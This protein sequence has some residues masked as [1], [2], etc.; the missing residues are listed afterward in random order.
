MPQ[1]LL[2]EGPDLEAL[3][4]QVRA[5]HGA[6][7]RIVKA[8]RVRTGGVAGFFA[9]QTYE[10]TVSVARASDPERDQVP[11]RDPASVRDQVPVRPGPARAGGS[12]QAARAGWRPAARSAPVPPPRPAADGSLDGSLDGSDDPF[13]V[14]LARVEAREQGTPAVAPRTAV[15]A[16]D[17]PAPRPPGRVVA[18]PAESVPEPVTDPGGDAPP[19]PGEATFDDVLASV[20][21]QLGMTEQPVRAGELPQPRIVPASDVARD[22]RPARLVTSPPESDDRP[23]SEIVSEI[24]ARVESSTGLRGPS[25]DPTVAP[26]AIAPDVPGAGPEPDPEGLLGDESGALL[27]HLPSRFP[28]GDGAEDLAGPTVLDLRGLESTDLVADPE[29]HRPDPDP[30]P[31]PAAPPA[32]PAAPAEPGAPGGRGAAGAAGAAGVSVGTDAGL[33][34]RARALGLP[35]DLAEAAAEEASAAGPLAGDLLP[36]VVGRRLAPTRSVII[37]P[38]AILVVAGPADVLA[39]HVA[40]VT[41]LSGSPG[42]AVRALRAVP[43]VADGD[44]LAGPDSVPGEAARAAAAGAPLVLLLPVDATLAGARRAARTIREVGAVGVLGVRDAQAGAG[45]AA[46]WL[47]DLTGGDAVRG[48]WLALVGCG[49]VAAAAGIAAAV[50]VVLLDG[51]PAGAGTWTAM[52]VDAPAPAES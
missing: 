1:H 35:A 22:W 32:V 24:V 48:R 40:P 37:G 50:D 42:A 8:E 52:L 34:D 44:T 25:G 19:R 4:T 3:L 46:R 6:A 47:D 12:V 30:D 38:G 14:L 41:A 21:A 17:G 20:R 7:A 49:D 33:L 13:E 29:Q 28:V 27:E 2:F 15:T 11:V 16:A 51:R 23:V 43:G 10:L 45:P 18:P 9:R 39:D 36:V 31:D 26:A 5:E